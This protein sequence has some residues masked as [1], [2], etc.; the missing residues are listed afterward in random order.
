VKVDPR[1]LKGIE[2]K[3]A[4]ANEHFGR[5]HGE[6]SAWDGRHPGGMPAW[7]LAPEVH[8]QGRK[9]FYRLRFLQPIPIDWAVILGEAIHDLRSALDQVVY[10]LTVDWSG[11]PLKNSSFPVNTRKAQ[12]EKRRK[13]GA[14]TNDS[15]MYKIRG[16]GPGPQA[17]IEALQPYPQRYRRFY[18]RDLRTV[19]DLWNQDKH[20]LVHL[21]GLRFRQPD[22]RL[23]QNIAEDCVFHVDRRVLQDGAIP[24]K[25]ICGT[26]HQNVEVRG[27]IGADLA[28]YSGK[29]RGGARES[30]WDTASTVADIIRK[31]L[32][33]V[34]RQGHAINLAAWTVKDEP[35][36]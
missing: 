23:P 16:V 8:D 12:F 6:M 14:W 3:I 1:A 11:K 29:R 21:F 20:R 36:V 28:F 26:P 24:L 7:R 9:H 2:R 34:G 13:N 31:L 10:W 35:L 27:E 22:L 30:L 4:R 18:C 5:L 17:F 15:G 25:L 19:H 33:A 32:N